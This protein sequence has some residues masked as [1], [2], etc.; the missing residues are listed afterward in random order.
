MTVRITA[1]QGGFRRCGIA[2]SAVA[3]TYPADSLTSAELKRLQAEPMLVVELLDQLA[4]SQWYH[5][6]AT[7]RAGWVR[8][9]A[10]GVNTAETYKPGTTV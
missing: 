8:V 9:F 10:N 3:T 4:T 6:A 1:K 7:R 2:H 5:V